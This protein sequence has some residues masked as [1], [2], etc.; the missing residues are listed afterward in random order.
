[1]KKAV[2]SL[3]AH[4]CT[5]E[6]AVEICEADLTP[7]EREEAILRVLS[8]GFLELARSVVAGHGGREVFPRAAAF[9]DR[10][11]AGERVLA[12]A[13]L[14]PHGGDPREPLAGV[15]VAPCL[16]GSDRVIVVFAG[17]AGEKFALRDDLLDAPDVHLVYLRDYGPKFLLCDIPRL[18]GSYEACRDALADIVHELGASRVFC[19]G[20]S[21]G[22]YASLKFG[23]DLRAEGVL[24]F[25]GPTTLSLADVPGA[26][27]QKFPQI[28]HLSLNAP[29]LLADM[30]SVYRVSPARPRVRL[31][32]GDAHKRDRMLA[33]R[34]DGIDGVELMPL[35]AF[36]GHRT[37]PEAIRRGVFSSHLS[38]LLS[39]RSL[40][41]G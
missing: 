13:G 27:L 32:F 28:R 1:M 14:E 3:K 2:K 38:D 12:A 34:M 15:L 24:N 17:L 30:A 31:V 25:S 19:L 36:D 22:G 37:F 10:V 4:N 39:F 23:F 16:S 21:A 26:T 41:D 29:H 5:Y 6:R 35:E 7:E 9:I 33:S 11:D 20:F 40:G 18:G 8:Y